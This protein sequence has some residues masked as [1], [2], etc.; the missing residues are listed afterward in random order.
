MKKY[1]KELINDLELDEADCCPKCIFNT[2][3]NDEFIGH[4]R[5]NL[6]RD[7][8]KYVCK[9]DSQSKT[10]EFQSKTEDLLETCFT[11][12]GIKLYDKWKTILNV[13][14]SYICKI[15]NYNNNLN[16]FEELYKY[17]LNHD[18]DIKE[19]L[20]QVML[21]NLNNLTIL[22]NDGFDINSILANKVYGLVA[23][24]DCQSKYEN[25]I[26]MINEYIKLGGELKKCKIL[27]SISGIQY[28]ERPYR[29]QFIKYLIENDY[30]DI[31]SCQ[32]TRVGS[33][34]KFLLSII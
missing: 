7:N 3:H 25:A 8:C 18:Y 21:L 32:E 34:I 33:I 30:I 11:K 24:L 28:D 20:N 9:Y 16:S 23:D 17:A 2:I 27:Q 26:K 13:D 12:G 29:I 15:F 5:I 22:V 1:T 31:T 19:N 4:C 14:N 6:I 10:N